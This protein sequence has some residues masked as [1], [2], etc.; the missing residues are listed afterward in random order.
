MADLNGFYNVEELEEKLYNGEISRKEFIEHHSEEW[1]EDFKK[2][3]K[4]KNIPEDDDA[5]EK[6]FAHRLEQEEKAHT[7]G[8]D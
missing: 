2:F 5:A 1:I 4:G 8:L 7:E 3:C 6:Y